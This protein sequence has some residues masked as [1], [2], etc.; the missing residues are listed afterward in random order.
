MMSD[1]MMRLGTLKFSLRRAAYQELTRTSE[2]R[3]ARQERIGTND[4][5]QYTGIGPETVQLSGAVFPTFVGSVRQIDRMRTLA[6][7][8]IPMP[9]VDGMGRVWGLWVITGLRETQSVFAGRGAP[10]RQ[11]YDLTLNRYDPG[12]GGLRALLSF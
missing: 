5:L 2:W 12:L 11:E 1:V 7:M 4:A 3:W 10:L 9:M 6:T 8:A